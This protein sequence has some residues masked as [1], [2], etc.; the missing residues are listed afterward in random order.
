MGRI[1]VATFNTHMGVG[2]DRRPYDLLEVVR[3]LDTDVVVLQEMRCATGKGSVLAE[4]QRLG[5]ETAVSPYRIAGS[6]RRPVPA[7]GPD[8]H[9][10]HGHGVVVLS[11]L[12]MVDVSQRDLVPIPG[13]PARRT[14][15]R[16]ALRDTTGH[17]WRVHATHVSWLPHGSVSHLTQLRRVLGPPRPRDL[18][19]GDLNMWGPIVTGLMRGW[20]RAVRGRTWPEPAPHSQIDHILV[21]ATVGVEEAGVTPGGASD[22]R[23]VWARLRCLAG[24]AVAVPRQAAPSTPRLRLRPRT[25][26]RLS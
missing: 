9:P 12:E 24:E 1:T 15:V 3:E 23:A 5:Y 20:R 14:V 26:G 11:R 16:V 13:D 21:G 19:A 17:I 25:P 7:G 2:P 22:H 18:V 4:A 6:S 10:A 8:S